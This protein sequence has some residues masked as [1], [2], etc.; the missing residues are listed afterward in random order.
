MIF[1][2]K[3]EMDTGRDVTDEDELD[4]IESQVI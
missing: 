3:D 4:E 1:V 2:D